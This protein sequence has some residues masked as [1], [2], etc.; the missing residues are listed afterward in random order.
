MDIYNKI[1]GFPPIQG[2]FAWYIRKIRAAN[3][4]NK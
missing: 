2:L 3:L 1:Q 4:L